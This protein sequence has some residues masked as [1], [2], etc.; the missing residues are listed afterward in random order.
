MC[1]K[2]ENYFTYCMFKFFLAMSLCNEISNLRPSSGLWHFLLCQSLFKLVNLIGNS[3]PAFVFP[4]FP[5][6]LPIWTKSSVKLIHCCSTNI[7]KNWK[8]CGEL[9]SSP[10]KK[11]SFFISFGS[12]EKQNLKSTTAIH[13]VIVLLYFTNITHQ[14]LEKAW[15]WNTVFL[16]ACSKQQKILIAT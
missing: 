16:A 5:S 14:L 8:V 1:V 12:S 3:N 2:V 9:D 11:Y 10:A 7:C 15:H 4:R 6:F 13:W